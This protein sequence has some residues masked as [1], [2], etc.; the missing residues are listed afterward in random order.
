MR[1]ERNLYGLRSHKSSYY[2]ISLFLLLLFVTSCKSNQLL[3]DNNDVENVTL[4]YRRCRYKYSYHR[5]FA[6]CIWK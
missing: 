3:I 4:V 5:L 1:K 2:S 6:H